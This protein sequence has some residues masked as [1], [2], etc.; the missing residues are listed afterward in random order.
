MIQAASQCQI[1]STSLVFPMIKVSGAITTKQ[2]ISAAVLISAHKRAAILW[3]PLNSSP[4]NQKYHEET[5]D[6][7]LSSIKYV[8][9]RT[10][11]ELLRMNS[12][13]QHRWLPCCW[14]LQSCSHHTGKESAEDYVDKSHSPA[15]ERVISGCNPVAVAKT[16]ILHFTVFYVVNHCF[17]F[18]TT[19]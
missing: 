14:T 8:W 9:E 5:L 1:L 7:S 2:N 15:D 11:G 3:L 12:Q 6:L 17:V 4:N 16:V 18:A 13:T 19:D 10:K